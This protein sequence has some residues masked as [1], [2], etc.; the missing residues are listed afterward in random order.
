MALEETG[1]GILQQL[2]VEDIGKSLSQAGE[3]LKDLSA[4]IGS[5]DASNKNGELSSQRMKA[6]SD[7]MI[8]AGNNLQGIKPERKPGKSWLKG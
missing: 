3:G 4:I 8:E 2:S 1:A 5:L 7:K 6:A